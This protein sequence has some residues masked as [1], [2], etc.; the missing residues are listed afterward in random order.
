MKKKNIFSVIL[1]VS[2]FLF[3]NLQAQDNK[4][5]LWKISGNGFKQS[6]YLFDT[7]HLVP[8][9]FADS[10]KGLQ[11]ALDSSEQMAGE[12]DMSNMQ[13]LQMKTMQGG[14]TPAGKTYQQLLS[15]EDY[16]LLEKSIK[17]LMGMGIDNFQKMSPAMLL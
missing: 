10:V 2:L 1:I 13:E 11:A 3:D 4:S 7:H 15:A 9:S 8:E 5:L 17:E 14:L 16:A 6:S 12:L